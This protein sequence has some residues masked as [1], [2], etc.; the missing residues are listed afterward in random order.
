MVSLSASVLT[1]ST[2]PL[3]IALPATLI[4]SVLAPEFT[5]VV[6]WANVLVTSMM[7]AP[8]PVF[9]VTLLPPPATPKP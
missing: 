8:P 4:V 1:L 5:F 9:R 2:L 3:P 6:P 7:F